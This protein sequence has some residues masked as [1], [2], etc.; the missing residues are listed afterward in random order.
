VIKLSVEKQALSSRLLRCFSAVFPSVY[1]GVAVESLALEKMPEWDSLTN[2]MLL[3]VIQEEFAV[4]FDASDLPG[5]TSF[6]EIFS[7]LKES[8]V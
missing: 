3:S 1:E 7:K 6:N 4:N 2:V 8:G 5:L